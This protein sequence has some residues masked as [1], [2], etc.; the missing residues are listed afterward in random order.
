MGDKINLVTGQE[1]HPDW[2]LDK[3][4]YINS[5]IM[6]FVPNKRLS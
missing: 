4:Y 5:I 2:N 3:D 6:E 1:I